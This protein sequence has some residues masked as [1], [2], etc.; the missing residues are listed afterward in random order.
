V[1]TSAVMKLIPAPISDAN[2]KD[3][4]V[5]LTK[6]LV[7]KPAKLWGSKV[8]VLNQNHIHLHKQTCKLFITIHATQ[9][10]AHH[11]SYLMVGFVSKALSHTQSPGVEKSP[12]WMDEKDG[13]LHGFRMKSK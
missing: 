2:W 6:I 13:G 7:Q 1:A 3:S 10:E 12:G 4:L 11:R 9:R 5:F 8:F